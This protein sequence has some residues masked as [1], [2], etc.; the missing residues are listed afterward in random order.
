MTLK[1]E[2]KILGLNLDTTTGHLF[3]ANDFKPLKTHSHFIIIRHGE[4]FGNC[5]QVTPN[6]EIDYEAVNLG[7]KDNGKRVFQGNVD[8]PINQL[9]LFGKQ[10]AERVAQLLKEKF[11]TRGFI[12][13]VIF[14]S[15][16]SRAKETGLPFVKQHG[17]EHN[18]FPYESIKEL[19]FGVWENRRVCDIESDH[20]C[21]SFYRDQNALVKESA[22]DKLNQAELGESFAEL[23]LRAHETLL[24]LSK[25]YANKKIILFSH[26]MFGAAA[27]ILFGK[28]Q[29]VENG[30]YLAFD[31]KKKNGETYTLPH[32]MP[33]LLS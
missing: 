3:Y 9:T 27:L 1:S 7:L 25:V 28:G 19:S 16:L 6:R 15:P 30:N 8:S 22:T 12:P 5:G 2:L 21:H 33:Y 10:Q 13:D 24:T 20:I 11:I 4:T 26:S 29:T 17:F 14:H 31:G 32:A 18:Y 23:I